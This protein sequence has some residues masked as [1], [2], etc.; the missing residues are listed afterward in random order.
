M[1]V[2][3]TKS[4][5]AFFYSFLDD[6]VK[7]TYPSNITSLAALSVLENLHDRLPAPKETKKNNSRTITL[8]VYEAIFVYKLVCDARQK[9]A[10]QHF[11]SN[12]LRKINDDIHQQVIS[13]SF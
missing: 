7:N 13:P 8:K 12:T 11:E 6:V 3:L 10:A 4:E 9:Y 5:F 1:K 2:N